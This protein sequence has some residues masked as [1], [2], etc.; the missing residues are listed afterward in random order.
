MDGASSL[1]ARAAMLSILLLGMLL[2]V[3]H[4]ATL[5]PRAVPVAAAPALSAEQIADVVEAWTGIP[6]GKMLQG[7]TAKLLEM[8]QV[9]GERLIGQ[10][11]VEVHWR[12][13]HAHAMAFGRNGRMQLGQRFRVIEPVGFRHEIK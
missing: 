2:C 12:F 4:L 1:R 6:T 8:E 10:Q 7:E 9:I 3:W 5:S 13:R 11:R